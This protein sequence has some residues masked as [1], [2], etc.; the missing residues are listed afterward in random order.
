MS[1]AMPVAFVG[2]GSPM[3]A[4]E[5][6]AWS[7]QWRLL[8]TAMKQPRAVLVVSAHWETDGP[9]ITG[10]A[11]PDT[12][13]D[14][15]GFPPALHAVQYPAPGDPQLAWHI[16]GLLGD[17]AVVDDERG[18][19][20]G[21]WSV[22]LPMFPQA[23]VPVLQLSLDR[24]LD[25]AGH[26]ALAKRL[27]SLRDE[28]VLVLAT[29][30]IVHNLRDYDFRASGAPA[31]ATAFRDRVVELVRRGDHRALCDWPSLPD[32]RRA[33]PSAEHYLPL[34]YML[35]LGRQDEVLRVFNDDVRS[36]IAMTSFV[37]SPD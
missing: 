2:H 37:A 31:W 36:A 3:N 33:I 14:F 12:I 4:I 32:R 1:Y 35:A 16:A 28:G 8:G 34:L 18:L 29:G 30:N 10:S 27:A 24:R 11:A 6:N 7:R 15:G 26:Y 21:A 13:H 17:D 22:L 20:H 19:D 23:D 25:G 9:R 5:D